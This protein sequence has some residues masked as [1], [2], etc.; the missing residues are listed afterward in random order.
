MDT[1]PFS[2]IYPDVD[3]ARPVPPTYGE[4]ISLVTASIVLAF[5]AA[6][7]DLLVMAAGLLLTLIAAIAPM[8]KTPRRIRNEARS[9]FPHE[10]WAEDAPQVIPLAIS[11]PLTWLFIIA[12]VGSALWFVPEK[13]TLW[14]AGGAAFLTALLVWFMPGLSP[15]WTERQKPELEPFEFSDLPPAQPFPDRFAPVQSHTSKA[16]D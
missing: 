7:G 14:G 1:P 12:I 5:G 4:R 9:R 10:Q 11:Y 13:Y 3:P 2:L 15:I 8:L 16:M 6:A